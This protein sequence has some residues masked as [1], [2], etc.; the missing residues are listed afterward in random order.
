[1]RQYTLIATNV[2]MISPILVA[3]S[4]LKN[5]MRLSSLPL[6]CGLAGFIGRYTLLGRRHA[7]CLM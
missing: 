1:M 2:P 5:S 7:S 3:G 4:W 6:A